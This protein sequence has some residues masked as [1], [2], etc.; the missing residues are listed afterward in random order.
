MTLR[1]NDQKFE[2]PVS[3]NDLSRPVL[4]RLYAF[5]NGPGLQLLAAG[6]EDLLRIQAATIILEF[7]EAFLEEW[8][9]DV[10][11]NLDAVDD[12]DAETLYFAELRTVCYAATNF[13]FVAP[14]PGMEEDTDSEAVRLPLAYTLTKNPYPKFKYKDR[15]DRIRRLYGPG[16]A[17]CNLSITELA[18]C[19]TL[20]E[21]YQREPDPALLDRLL[22]TMW[23]PA[24]PK[25]KANKRSNFG[26]D[27]RLPFLG[28]ETTVDD[29]LM[30]FRQLAPEVKNLLL[31][32]FSCCRHDFLAKYATVF[33][34]DQ[35]ERANDDTNDYGWG[36]LLLALSNGLIH[37]DAVAAQNCHNVLTYLS[38]LEDQALEREMKE[39]LALANRR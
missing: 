14:E 8:R 12:T 31:F 3:W 24:K 32:W 36:G 27:R 29:R 10:A 39:A 18:E 33:T 37:L 1:I 6:E 5:M 35:Q 34:T 9:R 7:E 26:G 22:A 30:I 17:F 23:R 2:L 4:L 25:T 15:R 20:Y 13:L 16:D 21:A 38:Y 19:F 11:D 28:H